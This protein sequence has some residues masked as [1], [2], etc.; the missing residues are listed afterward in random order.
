[1]VQVPNSLPKEIFSFVRQNEKEKIF[2]VFNFSSKPQKVKFKDALY[3]GQYTDFTLSEKVNL[4]ADTEL[5]LAPWAYKV[6]IK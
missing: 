1:M 3:I 4:T 5:W 6:F 2:A